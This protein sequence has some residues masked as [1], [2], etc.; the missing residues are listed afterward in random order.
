MSVDGRL[1]LACRTPLSA[2]PTRRLVVE[3]LPNLDVVRDL[4]VDMEPFWRSYEAVRPWLH[5]AA[6]LPERE[7][8]VD[9]ERM[10]RIDQ[11][12]NCVLCACCWGACPV[13]G[14][15]NGYLGPAALAKLFRFVDDPRDTRSPASLAVADAESGVWGCDGVYACIK[16]C[17]KE[18]RPYDG[19]NGL[20]RRLLADRLGFG[21]RRA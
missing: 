10:R 11:F 5:A 15:N 8:P 9:E 1:T 4:L 19:I 13:A 12:V 18:V 21:R 14:R 16:H 6:A 17:P 2:F 7:Q 20:R 3:P